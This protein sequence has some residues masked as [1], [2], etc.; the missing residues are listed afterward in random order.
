[1]LC[2]LFQHA[3]PPEAKQTTLDW[4][5]APYGSWLYPERHPQWRAGNRKK[6]HPLPNPAIQRCLYDKTRE[7]LTLAPGPG[8]DLQMYGH[9]G[10]VL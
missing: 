3:H 8:R 7:P 9:G 2:S 6:K 4:S 10:G 1:M 5:R